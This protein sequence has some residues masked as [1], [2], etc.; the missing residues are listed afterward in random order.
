ME[1]RPTSNFLS[2]ALSYYNSAP[3]IS[4][5]RLVPYLSSGGILS[6]SGVSCSFDP[7]VTSLCLCGES[8]ALLGRGC[9]YLMSNLFMYPFMGMWQV[10]LACWSS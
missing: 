1:L 10:L 5:I 7:Y 6:S 9:P 4:W 2:T 8:C 3:T